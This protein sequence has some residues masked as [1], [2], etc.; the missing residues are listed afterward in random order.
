MIY[1]FFIITVSVYMVLCGLLW[2]SEVEVISPKFT[3]VP[4]IKLMFLGMYKF[5]NLF[6]IC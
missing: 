3:C 4:G 2:R 1:Y 5:H 6:A